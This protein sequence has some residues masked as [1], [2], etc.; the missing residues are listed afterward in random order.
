MNKTKNVYITLP[1]L[2]IGITI[3]IGL[4]ML[5]MYKLDQ[6]LSLSAV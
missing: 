6:Y 1:E 4:S 2:L 5:F 3:F